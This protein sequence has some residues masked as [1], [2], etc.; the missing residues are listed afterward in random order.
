AALGTPLQPGSSLS[1][2]LRF[3]SCKCAKRLLSAALPA[4]RRRHRES[5]LRP[6]D[7][8]RRR[9]VSLSYE[10]PGSSPS[11]SALSSRQGD[12]GACHSTSAVVDQAFHGQFEWTS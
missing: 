6:G 4:V 2:T 1:R 11:S 3:C 9:G 7:P 8:V 10:T 12:S 5:L